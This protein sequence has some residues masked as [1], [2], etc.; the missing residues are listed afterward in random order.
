MGVN[1]VILIGNLGQKPEIRYTSSGIPMAK[2]SIAT[3]E[4]YGADESGN[5]KERTDWHRCTAWRRLAE[6]CGQY[7]DKGIKVYIEGRI[8][9]SEAVGQDGVKRYFTDIQVDNMQILTPKGAREYVPAEPQYADYPETSGT[10]TQSRGGGG[11]GGPTP[12]PDVDLDE[13]MDLDEDEDFL[14]G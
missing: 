11:G 14:A 12:P 2:F 7:L 1:K 6:I 4:R 3:T 8:H 5:R 10:R 13:D 9:Y